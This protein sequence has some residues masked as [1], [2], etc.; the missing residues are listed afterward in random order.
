MHAYLEV[1]VAG[2]AL[3]DQV[4]RYKTAVKSHWRIGVNQ[5]FIA[6][7]LNDNESKSV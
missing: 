5:N 1:H 6:P 4:K 3:E 7:L 2:G